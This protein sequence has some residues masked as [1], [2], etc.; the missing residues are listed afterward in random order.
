M[1]LVIPNNRSLTVAAQCSG[2][3]IA[4]NHEREFSHLYTA[5][6]NPT[7]EASWKSIRCE[8]TQV[9]QPNYESTLYFVVF[10]DNSGGE[11]FRFCLARRFSDQN[12]PELSFRVSQGDAGLAVSSFHQIPISVRI[13]WNPEC[14]NLD[15]KAIGTVAGRTGSSTYNR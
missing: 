9:I 14:S 12:S 11:H 2:C 1:I 8:G 13:F 4:P 10:C 7:R 15:C 3:Y 5:G 6:R